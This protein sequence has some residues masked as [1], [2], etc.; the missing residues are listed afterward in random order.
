MFPL[1]FATRVRG[2][3]RYLSNRY[4]PRVRTLRQSCKNFVA[5]IASISAFQHLLVLILSSYW[6]KMRAV[7]AVVTGVRQWRQASVLRK[8][9]FG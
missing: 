6:P 2:L 1:E 8:R 3:S 9:P 5:C 7:S 4:A